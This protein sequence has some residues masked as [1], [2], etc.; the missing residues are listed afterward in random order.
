[1]ICVKHHDCK[2]DLS[3]LFLT[4][5]DYASHPSQSIPCYCLFAVNDEVTFGVLEWSV[6]CLITVSVF[7]TDSF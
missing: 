1:M 2:T 4:T 6:F 5:T 3:F 7:M